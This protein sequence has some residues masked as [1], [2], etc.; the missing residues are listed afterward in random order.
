MSFHATELGCK[1][2]PHK[3][4]VNRRYDFDCQYCRTHDKVVCRCGVEFGHHGD[5]CNKTK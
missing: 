4:I 3:K 2:V 1:L 5:D